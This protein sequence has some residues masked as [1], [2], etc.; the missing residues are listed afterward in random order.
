MEYRFS[1]QDAIDVAAK[2][3]G[4]DGW[5]GYAWEA[6]DGGSIVRGCVPDGVYSKGPRKGQPKFS[7]PVCGTEKTVVVALEELASAA[8]HHERSTGE[9]WD[10]KGTG[11]TWAGWSA[12]DGNRY[13]TCSRCGGSGSAPNMEFR[14]GLEAKP[15]GIAPGTQG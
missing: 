1:M 14:P 3:V 5:E 9:C 8:A 13:K 11:Q 2:K 10:C 4:I 7:N 6:A 12:A 15:E